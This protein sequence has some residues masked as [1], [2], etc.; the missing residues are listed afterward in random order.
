M[1]QKRKEVVDN[2]R[3]NN[4]NTARTTTNNNQQE[5]GQEEEQQQEVQQEEE[6]NESNNNSIPETNEENLSIT[7]ENEDRFQ[8]YIGKQVDILDSVNYWTEAEV[9][10][11]YFHFFFFSSS[12][13][14]SLLHRL[15][16][17]IKRKEESISHIC[18]GHQDGMNGLIYHQIDLHHYI[19]ILIILQIL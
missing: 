2:N 14:L 18:I 10:F 4:S 16:K 8:L 12:Y 7:N 6:G 5:D 17:L 3:D 1:T 9:L 15:L 13:F 19:H 11:S